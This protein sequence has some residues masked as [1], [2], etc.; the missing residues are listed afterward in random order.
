MVT[1]NNNNITLIGY[2]SSGKTT[3]AKLYA[4]KYCC[5]FIDTDELLL[6]NSNYSNISGFYNN[7]GE[8]QFRNIESK[9]IL[10]LIQNISADLSYIIATGGGVVLNQV[11]IENLKRISKVIYIDTPLE[12][13]INR[14]R[15]GDAPAFLNNNYLDLER[16]IIINYNARNELYNKSCDY[17]INLANKTSHEVAAEIFS[18][19]SRSGV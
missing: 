13:I 3:I 17:R 12:I 15:D 18:F 14:I 10:D 9:I 1:K 2:K 4:K 16:N 7:K 11:N 19:I 8:I 5:E 6:K